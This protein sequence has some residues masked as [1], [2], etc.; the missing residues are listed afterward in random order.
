M[1]MQQSG[2]GAAASGSGPNPALSD[3][4]AEEFASSFTP[5]WDTGGDDAGP[6]AEASQPAQAKAFNAKQTLIG[7][8]PQANA[9]SAGAAASNGLE[10]RAIAPSSEAIDPENILE[11]NT[12]PQPGVVAP[13]AA[14]AA[15]VAAAPA[16]AVAQMTAKSTMV[17]Q[18]APAQMEARH[19]AARA[20]AAAPAPSAKNARG[21][22]GVTADPFRVAAGPSASAAA[23][24]ARDDDFDDE[25]VPKKPKTLL[26]VLAGLAIAGAVGLVV[27]LGTG[28]DSA[29]STPTQ[30]PVG[31]AATTAEIPPP[32]PKV[33]T[34][35]PA[36]TTATAAA[37]TKTPEPP[38]AL[39]APTTPA[40]PT[41]PA[42][43]HVEA[44][45]HAA[46]APQPRQPRAAAAPPEPRTS[47]AAAGPAPQ[48]APKTPPK[49]PN[50]GIVRDNPF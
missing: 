17:M 45:A 27:K 44:P 49:G 16:A 21:A 46:P 15:P 7:T 9:P 50:G 8:A 14:A 19:A 48:P 24:R 2:K 36:A 29:K 38:A 39:A 30:Q 13:V 31:P 28:D 18:N 26:F 34:P 35:P 6:T 5:A 41:P 43:A 42:A 37:T 4:Q 40:T 47:Q 22:A 25:I 23:Q 12:A 32:P 20:A 1:A 11:S 33:E 3:E 10:A